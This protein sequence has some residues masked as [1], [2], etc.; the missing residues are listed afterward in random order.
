MYWEGL[1]LK[2]SKKQQDM[3]FSVSVPASE[4]LQTT[5]VYKEQNG[6]KK[7]GT[8]TYTTNKISPKKDFTHSTQK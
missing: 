3:L 6:K 2:T 1:Y 5:S 8:T 7:W 4:S